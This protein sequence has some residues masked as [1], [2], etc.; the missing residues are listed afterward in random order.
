MSITAVL[1]AHDD[2]SAED[3]QA[4]RALKTAVYPPAEE[5]GWEGAAREWAAH[6]GGFSYATMPGPWCRRRVSFNDP[7][8]WTVTGL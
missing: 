7:G 8:Q 6:N 5:K 1:K 3:S 2:F 4:L